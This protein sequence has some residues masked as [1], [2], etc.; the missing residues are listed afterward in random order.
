VLADVAENDG[1]AIIPGDA[2]QSD[3]G[4]DS[5]NGLVAKEPGH[6]ETRGN[7]TVG[8]NHLDCARGLTPRDPELLVA[9]FQFAVL[10]DGFVRLLRQL[11]GCWS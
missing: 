10:H 11:F 8:A 2:R 4:I 6:L 3:T 5:L 7:D 1:R 9:N